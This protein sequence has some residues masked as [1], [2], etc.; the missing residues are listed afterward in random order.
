M[1]EVEIKWGI[2]PFRGD[3]FAAGWLPAAEA[4]LAFGATSWSF[5]RNVEGGLDFVQT[6]RFPSKAHFEHYWYSE[7]IADKRVEMAG[8]FQVPLLPSFWTVVGSGE[9]VPEAVD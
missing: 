7:E 1:I 2:N 5:K 8:Y 4:A 3:K 9:L 6:A